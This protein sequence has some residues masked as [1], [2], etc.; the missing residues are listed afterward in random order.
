[1]WDRDPELCADASDRPTFDLKMTRNRSLR[2]GPF[3]DPHIV[4]A[5][6]MMQ[7]AAVLA[8][9]LLKLASV[10]ERPL[11]TGIDEPSPSKELRP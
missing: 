1:M 7:E 4:A 8:E 5:A 6:V 11:L 2:K 9:M 3:V 10:Q